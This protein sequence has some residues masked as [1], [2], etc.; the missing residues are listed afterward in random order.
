[1]ADSI[2]ILEGL[3]DRNDPSGIAN[4]ELEPIW[5]DAIKR[6]FHQC[7]GRVRILDQLAE[8]AGITEVSSLEDVVPLLFAHTAYKSYPESFIDRGQWD[9]MNLW[10]NTLSKDPVQGVNV[11]GIADSDEWVKRLH[12]AGHYVFATSGTSGKN[13]FNIDEAEPICGMVNK[14]TAGFAN[15]LCSYDCDEVRKLAAHNTVQHTVHGFDWM[16]RGWP[17]DQPA[18]S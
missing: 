18:P 6:R 1:M 13:S 17:N 7:R 12:D 14:Q 15:G 5:V 11:G 16:S 2:E 4:E 8:K 9:R 3:F 10:L